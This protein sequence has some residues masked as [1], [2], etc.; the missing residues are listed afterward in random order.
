MKRCCRCKETKE[1]DQFHKNRSTVDGYNF[2]CKSCKKVTARQS[3]GRHKEDVL[4]KNREY[5]DANL[6][7]ILGYAREY[8]KENRH[9]YRASAAERE[10]KRRALK[11]QTTI[12]GNQDL[13]DLVFQEAYEL[14]EARTQCTGFRHHVDHI[15]PLQGK[16]AC[17]FH[18]WNNLRVVPYYENLSKSNKLMEDL[19]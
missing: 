8:D 6:Q 4:A 14:S 11:L 1:F 16:D 7:K 3:Y 5:Y 10:N 13:N 17:G 12:Y 9:K 18:V 15:I 2:I 19:L